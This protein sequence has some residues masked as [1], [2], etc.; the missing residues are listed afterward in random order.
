MLGPQQIPVITDPD[1]A[2]ER[3]AIVATLEALRSMDGDYVGTYT[4]LIMTT[5]PDVVKQLQEFG[6]PLFG[7]EYQSD[8]MKKPFEEGRTE[9]RTQALQKAIVDVL[10]A[11][12]IALSDEGRRRVTGC[13]DAEMLQRWVVRAAVAASEAD[14]WRE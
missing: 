13:T 4:D 10:A 14:L 9:G 3:A 1:E 8:M 6:M 2:R 5:F 11:R 12:A 7:Y